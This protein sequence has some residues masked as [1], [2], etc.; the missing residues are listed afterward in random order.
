MKIRPLTQTVAV[1]IGAA[2]FL[3]ACSGGGEADAD[4]AA[5][6]GG[7]SSTETSVTEAKEKAKPVDLAALAEKNLTASKAYLEEN[8]KRDD[9][10]VTQSGLQYQVLEEGPEGG[11]TPTPADLVD[12]H[13][14][15][16]LIDGV[17][18]DSS[19]A[20]GAAARFL[21]GQVING[22][23][24]AL[25]LMSE[26]D[27]YR[28][29]IPPE[30]AYG[31]GGAGA[32]IGPNQALIFDVELL[33][34]TNPE[35]NLAAATEFLSENGK[36]EGVV[37]TTSGLQ[38]KIINEGTDGAA[39]PTDANVVKVHYEGRLIDGTIFDSS[40]ERG[41][42]AEFPLG[43][44]I[45]GWIEGVQ[46]MS[47]GDKYQFYIKPE[48]AYGVAGRPMTIGPNELLVFDVEL[49]EVKE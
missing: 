4:A 7:S 31:E 27:R 10:T 43:R 38:Y 49:L 22:W 28:L 23:V 2:A 21:A 29:H 15:G 14:V 32:D 46:L 35:I 19:R 11:R 48:L 36:K 25:Q 12:V 5:D 20:R 44:V 24:E 6:S 42:P 39:S 26:G 41:E 16:T 9:V 40:Y 30:L 17:E 37:T 18:F 33:K 3:A 47:E 45:P 34:V 1:S 13:Y 8:A